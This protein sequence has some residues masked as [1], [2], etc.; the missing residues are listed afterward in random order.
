MTRER[1]KGL[2]KHYR[3]GQAAEIIGLTPA[4]FRTHIKNGK[5]LAT[6]TPGGHWRIAESELF[7]LIGRPQV[8][9]ETINTC[10]I[11]AR[12]SSQKQKV[13]GNLERQTIRLRGFARDQQLTVLDV[14]TDVGSGLNEKRK[15]LAK[16][17]KLAREQQMSHVLIEFRDRLTRFGYRFITDYFLLNGIEVIVKEEEDKESLKDSDLNKELVDDLIA[18]IHS[19]SGRLYGRRSAEFRKI[20]RCIKQAAEKVD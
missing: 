13:A 7:R 16:L 19:F 2:E 10:V 18:I 14:I 12:V 20:K 8:K 3:I 9:N 15:G 5:V 4:N 1:Q 17:F 6:K 11:Y